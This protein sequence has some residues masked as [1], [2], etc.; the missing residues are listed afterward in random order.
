[1]PAPAPV[2]APLAG[3]AASASAPVPAAPAVPPAPPKSGSRITIYFE[4][5]SRQPLVTPSN[6][7]LGRKPS[8]QQPG[9]VT[10][11]VPDRTGTVSRSHAR[12][13]ITAGHLWITD[14]GSTNGTRV[15][16]EDGNETK[17]EAHSRHA[18]QSGARISLGDMGCSI[19]TAKNRGR[20]S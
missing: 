19:I 15:T 8:P 4:D 20:R 13:E 9:D 3:H 17:L 7:V 14:L 11:A 18:I 10:L 5:G 1:M 2:P 16:D 12:L 6:V